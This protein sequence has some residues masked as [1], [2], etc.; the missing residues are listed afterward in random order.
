MQEIV[1]HLA[2]SFIDNIFDLIRSSL[3]EKK[4]KS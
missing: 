1:S 2:K 4:E 3:N